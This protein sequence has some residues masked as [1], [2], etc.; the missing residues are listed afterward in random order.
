MAE[1]AAGITTGESTIQ[2]Q[3]D[4]AKKT[5][6][7]IFTIFRRSLANDI[8]RRLEYAKNEKMFLDGT[9]LREND[10][11]D[12][13]VELKFATRMC[14]THASYVLKDRPNIQ[15][16]PIAPDVPELRQ[17]A[18][19]VERSLNIWWDEQKMAPKLKLGILTASYKWDYVFFLSYNK[20]KETFD[21]NSLQPDFFSYDRVGV[22]P[23]SPFRWT[24]RIDLINTK[25]LKIKYPKFKDVIT[26]SG[27]NSR[28]LS[29]SGFF[30]SDLWNLEKSCFISIM[31]QKYIYNY[32]NDI[33]V[34]VIEHNYPFIPFY[35]FKYFDTWQK[36]GMALMSFIRDPIRFINQIL[37]Y[38]FDLALKVSNP[39]LIIIG[40]NANIDSNNLKGGKIHL[41]QGGPG[42]SVAYLQPPQSNMQM[43][44]VQE[45]MKQMMHF[46]SGLNEE[47]MAGF[48]G[49]LT[50]AG[51]SI[52]MRM[53]ATVREALDIQ[54]VLQEMLQRI[55]RD[56]LK[57]M[58]QFF[59][60][61]NL[62]KS[63]ELWLLSDREFKASLIGGLYNN[64]VDFG[65]ILPR[66]DSEN[67]RNVL[68]KKQAYL[69]SANTALEELRYAD[70]GIELDQ[71]RTEKIEEARLAA[72]I[73]AGDQ[74]EQKFFDNPKEEEDYMLTQEKLAIPH[75]AQNAEEHLKSHEARY[76]STPSPLIL[77]HIIMTQNIARNAMEMSKMPPRENVPEE[78]FGAWQG[79]GGAPQGWPAQVMPPAW[80]QWA[81]QYQH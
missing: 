41:P 49:A 59:P 1:I 45:T 78:Q 27:L 68:A 12:H 13:R 76:E 73:Q 24:M 31:D 32:I 22:D 66:S 30:R 44:K 17:H 40:G 51:I 77:Q 65:G 29:F 64:I 72:Q 70:P 81:P 37:G 26:P 9:Q 36:W 11:W 55:N 75:P 19:F 74:P 23:Y 62:F 46:L 6:D 35:L 58:Q 25:D 80:P 48:T 8:V 18:S 63:H 28:F 16:P 43:D 5:S 2:L 10:Y 54:T 4:P 14:R 53:D 56:Y 61:K 21:F 57:L 20:A 3:V 52:E 7:E 33:E 50:S 71:V 79:G 60:N 42:T 34:E 39:P 67:V 69:I 47:A 15:V 38:Q